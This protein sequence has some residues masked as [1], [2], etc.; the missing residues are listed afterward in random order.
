MSFFLGFGFA[1][2]LVSTGCTLLGFVLASK[3]HPALVAGLLFLTPG[4]FVITL[5]RSAR[6]AMDWLAILLGVGLAPVMAALIG[7]GLDL[8]G[9]GLVVG[10]L[11]YAARRALRARKAA[12][13]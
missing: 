8:M 12:A 3:L 10:G 11:A 5:M 1:C 13:T 2:I 4:Y 9:T 6:E 7:G